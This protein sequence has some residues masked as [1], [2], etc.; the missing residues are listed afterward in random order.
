MNKKFYGNQYIGKTWRTFKTILSG[1]W[2]GSKEMVFNPGKTL[3]AVLVLGQAFAA[4]TV[5]A[6]PHLLSIKSAWADL[7]SDDEIKYVREVVEVE[8]E[9]A[10][11]LAKIARCE[12][13]GKQFHDNGTLVKRVNKDGSID[14]GKIPNQRHEARTLS[15]QTWNEHLHGGGQRGMREIFV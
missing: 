11:I 14:F 1:M 2:I 12:S 9:P 15:S 3:L 10:V 7:T 13:G 8:E 5:S 4:F 6:Q